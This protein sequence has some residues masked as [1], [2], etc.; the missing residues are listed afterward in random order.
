MSNTV[1]LVCFLFLA[2]AIFSAF[3]PVAVAQTA[4]QTPVRVDSNLVV[5]RAVVEDKKILGRAPTDEE[6]L[7]W[8]KEWQ[9]LVQLSP[10]EPFIP[11][12]CSAQRVP[13]LAAANFHVFADGT[14]QKVTGI[15]NERNWVV[16]RDN[17]GVHKEHSE[18]PSGIWSNSDVVGVERFSSNPSYVYNIA[19]TPGISNLSGCQKIKI[20]VD[21]PN[22]NVLASSEYCFSQLPSDT[23][24]GTKFGDQM[25]KNLRTWE[26]GKLP[27]SLQT[28]FVFV[29]QDK[30]RVYISLD[31]A[32]DSLYRFW[33]NDWS[34]NAAIG[35]LGA[36][37][38][39]DG[40]EVAQ[41]SEL[42]CCTDYN[43]IYLYM[44]RLSGQNLEY[45]PGDPVSLLLG[46][47]EQ[48]TL[49]TRYATQVELAPG[50][51]DPRIV[52]SDGQ[53]FGRV[54]AHVIIE[55]RG[56]G[57]SLSSVLL[58]KRIRDAHAAAVENAAAN[59]APNYVPLVSKGIQVIPTG[60]TRFDECKHLYAYFEV[61]EPQLTLPGIKVQ[62]NVRIADAKTGG[63][64]KDFGNIDAAPYI[65][66][67]STVIPVGREI[68]FQSLPEGSYRLE[69]Q[70]TDSSGQS[71]A[72]RTANFSV[73]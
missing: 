27:V 22:S 46:R 36:F 16:V 62:A 19:F 25:Q 17:E 20:K 30:A 73:E 31:F 65:N 43:S 42:A 4:E 57:L 45:A 26:P 9:T 53:K 69:V 58:G 18:T 7:C 24:N 66:A 10:E 60:D 39:E 33:E 48:D 29:G 50:G 70:A 23:L 38:K 59:F 71:T 15:T 49:P 28:G 13:G 51:Y 1:R 47:T 8:Q 34:L 6:Q 40:S 5:V 14:E 72:W 32:R 21:R 63:I 64:K 41:F 55:R 67:G 11:K 56:K 44:M 52:L 37:Y 61:Y 54:D 3:V 68:P 2:S 12:I 35:V